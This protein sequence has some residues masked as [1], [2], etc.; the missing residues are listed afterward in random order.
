MV[1]SIYVV[2]MK[3]FLENLS[4]FLI[5]FSFTF[6]IRNHVY[7]GVALGTGIL[8]LLLLNIRTI[9]LNIKIT[10]IIPFLI[11]SVI[12]ILCSTNSILPERSFPVMIYLLL[13]SFFSFLIFLCLK[14]NKLIREKIKKYFF[15]I[16]FF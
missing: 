13:I 11:F 6:L 12:L 5:S 8:I 14:E 9:K 15:L 7:F 2:K 4:I 1:C 16:L 3:N 10:K